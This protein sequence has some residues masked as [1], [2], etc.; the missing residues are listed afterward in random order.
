MN[1]NFLELQ[2]YISSIE[3]KE[4]NLISI[5][6]KTQELMGCVSKDSQLLIHKETGIPLAKIYGVATFYPFFTLSE[7]EQKENSL[8][9]INETDNQNKI[10]LKNFKEIDAENIETYISVGGYEALKKALTMTNLEIIDEIEIARLRGRGGAGFLTW[11]KFNSVYRQLEAEKYVVCNGNEGEK[12]AFKDFYL[13]E[14][15]PHLIIEGILIAGYTVKA[16]KGFIY[17][18]SDYE[19]MLKILYK[20]IEDAKRKNFLG[21]RILGTEFSFEIEIRYG[22]GA[23][24][25]GEESALIESLQGK[26]GEPQQR[27]PFVYQSGYESKPTLLNNVETIA[28]IP[29][30]ILNGGEWFRNI[31][32]KNSTGTK[33]V[34]LMGNIK[35]PGIVEIEMGMSIRELL[36]KIGGG[37][38]SGKKIKAIQSGGPEGVFITQ[39]NF[40][41]KVE[42]DTMIGKNSYIGFNGIKILDEDDSIVE[43]IKEAIEF[44][45]DSSCGK[46]TPCRIGTK[47]IYDLL[48]KISQG[49]G[50]SQDIALIIELCEALKNSAICGLGKSVPVPILSALEEFWDEFEQH[51]Q[52]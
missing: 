3:K 22:A 28:N 51:F 9:I 11:K 41:K 8:P 48:N 12:Y 7:T 25:C 24:V 37:C 15:N 26:R 2:R 4:E 49:K 46:C 29:N 33:I 1:E 30:I 45:K 36:E 13:L 27:P 34:T 47:K 38:N 39:K 43:A 50:N 35:R 31:G 44:L 20:A 6:K 32:T 14:N 18:R 17:V 23:Y 42:L 40:D 16:K 19:K 5:L 52:F 10:L 21:N